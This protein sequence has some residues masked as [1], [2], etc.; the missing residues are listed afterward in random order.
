MSLRVGRHRCTI[1]I[2]STIL[3]FA[4]IIPSL[5]SPNARL[6]MNSRVYVRSFLIIVSKGIILL[7]L[8]T[9]EDVW[10]GTCCQWGDCAYWRGKPLT[11]WVWAHLLDPGFS[12]LLKTAINITVRKH[13]WCG[14][15]ERD[16]TGPW[17]VHKLSSVFVPCS[18]RK[19]VSFGNT[20]ARRSCW[21]CEGLLCRLTR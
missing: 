20:R 17:E 18:L 21:K 16:A 1:L 8:L 6:D 2:E 9:R 13:G 15:W 4:Q 7:L 12:M 10:G 19:E 14:C 5:K 11:L 3:L